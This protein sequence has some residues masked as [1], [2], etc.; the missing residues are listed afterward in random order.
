MLRSFYNLQR[1]NPGFQPD[2]LLTLRL[3]LPPARY[4]TPQQISAFYQQL[5]ERLNALP[6]VQAVG[7]ATWMPL[8]GGGSQADLVVEGQPLPEPGQT[9]FADIS[10]VTPDYFHLMGIVLQRGRAFNEQ[11]NPNAP[12]VVI[13]DE[14]TA[15]RH[16]PDADP[17]GKRIR[18]GRNNADQPWATVVGIVRPVKLYGL[19]RE[20]NNAQVYRSFLQFSPLVANLAVRSTTDP[21]SLTTAVRQ[22]VLAL[23]RDLPIFNVKTMEQALTDSVASQRLNTLLLG[24]F[25]A[26]AFI[27]AAVGIYGVMSYLVAQRTQEI[28]IRLALGAQASAVLRLILQQG[29]TL[30]LAGVGA[31]VLLALALTRVLRSLLFGVSATDLLTFAGV[32]SLLLLVA[33]LACWIPARRATKV[34]PLTALRTE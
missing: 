22:Q 12:P 1:V 16:W 10:L 13:L 26:V 8:I 27:L 14:L 4:T 15:Q 30:A 18:L 29:M 32:S 34:D 20:S 11:D 21:T 28:G 5:L 33:L 9:P 24:L 25:A 2:H 17:I 6:G 31:G 3:A 7:A 23:D 19:A